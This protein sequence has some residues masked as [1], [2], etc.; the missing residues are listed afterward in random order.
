MI[1]S[2]FGL[3]IIQQ[4][5]GLVKGTPKN[6]SAEKSFEASPLTSPRTCC[7]PANSRRKEKN[8][9]RYSADSCA[10]LKQRYKR[11]RKLTVCANSRR[12]FGVAAPPLGSRVSPLQ[13]RWHE[14]PEGLTDRP[15]FAPLR[16]SGGRAPVCASVPSLRSLTLSK[17]LSTLLSS[18]SSPR[19]L[20]AWRARSRSAERELW[21]GSPDW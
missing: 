17:P 16:G 15:S 3:A 9:V 20:R 14:V 11:G 19:P 10:P 5:R 4:L 13:G 18:S 2:L 12:G 21:R 1:F 7:V 8:V 6:F